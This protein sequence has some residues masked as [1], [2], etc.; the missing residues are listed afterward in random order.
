MNKDN[1][2]KPNEK[3]PAISI[4]FISNLPNNSHA[5][6]CLYTWLKNLYTRMVCLSIADCKE[7]IR[8]IPLQYEFYK[9]Y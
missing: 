9:S 5:S 8:N 6:S 2:A 1:R 4:K 3:F 7:M